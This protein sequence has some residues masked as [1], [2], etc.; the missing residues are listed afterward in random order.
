MSALRVATLNIWHDAGPWER[1][2]ALIRR[3]LELLGPDLVGLQE[4]L[5]GEGGCQAG[6]L[7]DGLGYEV[8]YTGA[9]RRADGRWHGNALLSRLPLRDRAGRALPAGGVEPRALLC[10]RVRTADGW[11]PVFVTHL[12]YE[13]HL[14]AVRHEQLRAIL[15]EVERFRAP[16]DLPGVLLADLN[17]VPGS[18]EVGTL[19]DRWLDA[20]SAG[21]G[22]GVTFEPANDYARSWE[23]PPQRLDYVFVQRDPRVAVR[24]A[25]TAF[26][27]PD[28]HDGLLVW[29]SDHYGVVADL[30]LAQ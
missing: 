5:R 29:P 16:E 22:P 19:E 4:V 28:V 7:A 2:R 21:E 27:T 17:S 25:A 18:T 6:E 10:A 12:T 11:I 20:W 30:E 14:A 24:H 1:R 3:E 13:A 23:E 9:C 15:A 8:A 26:A